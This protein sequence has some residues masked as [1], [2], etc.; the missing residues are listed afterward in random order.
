MSTAD[1]GRVHHERRWTLDWLLLEQ[2]LLATAYS[3]LKAAMHQLTTSD[4]ERENF[5]TVWWEWQ[6][7]ID[8]HKSQIN[9]L[10]N[11]RANLVPYDPYCHLATVH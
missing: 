1:P 4:L 6:A 10:E 5:D 9:K 2:R 8:R 11:W 7:R 3:E